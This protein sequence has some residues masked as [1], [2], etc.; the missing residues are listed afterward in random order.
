MNNVCIQ[1]FVVNRT[2][3]NQYTTNTVDYKTKCCDNNLK[4]KLF[5]LYKL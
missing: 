3:E 5:N 4:C 1:L 2:I